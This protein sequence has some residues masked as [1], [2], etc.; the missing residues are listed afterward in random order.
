MHFTGVVDGI[1]HIKE[2]SVRAESNPPC[3]PAHIL[4]TVVVRSVRCTGSKELNAVPKL[5]VGIEA[6]RRNM[7]DLAAK[8]LW[9]ALRSDF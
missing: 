7:P 8:R 2:D 9:R 1:R 3:E 6:M 5:S 4:V